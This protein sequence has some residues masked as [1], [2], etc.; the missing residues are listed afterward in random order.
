MNN[1]KTQIAKLPGL[2]AEYY[3]E[4]LALYPAGEWFAPRNGDHQDF[5]ICIDLHQSHLIEK[6]TI[7]LWQDGSF[8]GHEIFFRYQLDLKYST[9]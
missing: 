4:R 8:K 9:P 1:L 2:D 6:A 7:P 3:F 5:Q